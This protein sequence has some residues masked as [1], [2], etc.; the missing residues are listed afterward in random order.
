MQSSGIVV[1]AGLQLEPGSRVSRNLLIGTTY[2]DMVH[3]NIK[4]IL[5]YIIIYHVS[6]IL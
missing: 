2:T 1:A 3:D 5:Y 6:G 4:R